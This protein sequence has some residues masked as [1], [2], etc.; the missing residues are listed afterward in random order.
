MIYS[1]SGAELQRA[2]SSW[3]GC[4]LLPYCN[5]PLLQRSMT[6]M[7]WQLSCVATAEG[8]P[9]PLRSDGQ[10]QQELVASGTLQL[11]GVI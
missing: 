5:G 9:Q 2:L 10:E 7:S 4:N 11:A 8:E 1:V 3:D 6:G